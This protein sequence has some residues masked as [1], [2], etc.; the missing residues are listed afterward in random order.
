MGNEV[1]TV[2]GGIATVGT[3]VAAGV[4]FGQVSAL[5]NAVKETAEFTGN[6][7]MQ[8]NVRHIGQTA[9]LAVGTAST[10]AVA[11]ICLGQVEGLNKATAKMAE[12]TG[13]AGKECG[14]VLGETL[15]DTADGL[16]LIGHAK[17]GI[18]YACGDHKG[19]EKAMK[20]SSRT[21]AVVGGAVGGFCVG[22]PAGAVAGGVAGGVAVDGAVTGIDSAV[23]RKFTPYGQVAAWAQVVNADNAQDRVDGIVTGLT[24]PIMDGVT[25]YQIGRLTGAVVEEVQQVKCQRTATDFLKEGGNADLMEALDAADRMRTGG[26]YIAPEPQRPDEAVQYDGMPVPE[27]GWNQDGEVLYRGD[28]RLEKEQGRNRVFETGIEPHGGG[29]NGTD[30]YLHT[31]NAAYHN[32]DFV[33]TSKSYALAKE[34]GACGKH[35]RPRAHALTKLRVVNGVDINVTAR[36]LG[37]KPLYPGQVEVSVFGGVPPNLIEGV[38]VLPSGGAPVWYPNPQFQMPAVGVNQVYYIRQTPTAPLGLLVTASVDPDAVD[39]PSI[40]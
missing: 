8:T 33:S 17:G 39:E 5:N 1:S 38:L 31:E 14:T 35:S 32:Q 22:G 7:F 29:Q 30:A 36:T 37:L 19:G 15:S 23:K 3:S 25:G 28:R 24:A 34:F 16:P 4:C 20:A 9:G 6:K 26:K 10:G 13:A 12:L 2:G 40:D 27:A 11:G 21:T 18:H